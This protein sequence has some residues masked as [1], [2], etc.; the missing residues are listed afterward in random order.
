MHGYYRLA[1]LGTSQGILRGG[2][3]QGNTL[4]SPLEGALGD[5]LGDIPGPILLVVFSIWR[6][7]SVLGGYISGGDVDLW[8]GRYSWENPGVPR[9]VNLRNP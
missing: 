3:P 7:S 8:G 4:G 6:L 5:S 1:S 9:L 2:Y